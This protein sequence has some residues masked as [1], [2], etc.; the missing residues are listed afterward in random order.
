VLRA[1]LLGSALLLALA[2]CRSPAAAPSGQAPG[3]GA[4]AGPSGE[5]VVYTASDERDATTAVAAFN[6]VYPNVKVTMVRNESGR[7]ALLE[8]LLTELDSGR[9]TADLYETGIPD[10]SVLLERGDI[11]SYRSPS[12]SNIDPRFVFEDGFLHARDNLIFM[13]AYNKNLLSDADLPRTWDDLLLPRWKGKIATDQEPNDIVAGFLILMGRDKGEAYLRQL[14]QNT[15]TRRGRTLLVDLL[16]AG[17]Y[18]MSIDVYA[19]RIAGYIKDGAPLGAVPLPAYFASPF[20]ESIL[21]KAPN[22]ENAKRWVDWIQSPA[23]QETVARLNRG[24]VGNTQGSPHP[25]GKLIEGR[26]LVVLSPSKL[27]MSYNEIARLART[28]LVTSGS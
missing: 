3:A 2:G 8:R 18:P 24:P 11:L 16:A 19:H 12:E 22:Q 26:E 28:I 23:G 9:T 6:E 1:P 7:G 14:A 21:K 5:L 25:F 27:P 15:I 10:T 20:V 4:N 17:E 13:T